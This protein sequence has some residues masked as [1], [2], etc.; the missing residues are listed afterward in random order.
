MAR[1]TKA[2]RNAAPMPGFVPPQL[3]TLRPKLPA[4]AAWIHEAKFDGYRLQLHKH[5]KGVTIYTRSGL[6]WTKRFPTIAADLA[7]L[8]ATRLIIDG[9]LISAGEDG[10]ANFS[11]L[12]DDLKQ[13]RYDRMVFY[14]FDL[15]HSD[16]V[17][18]RPAPLLERKDALGALLADAPLLRILLSE[19]FDDGLA[20]FE[21]AK[22]IGLEGVV[23]KRGDLPYRI[24]RGESWIKV[25]CNKRERF[26]IVG[27][28]HEGSSGIAKLRLAR[29]GT[30]V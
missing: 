2:A 7:R 15:L 30:H 3:A 1:G 21:R 26:V 8:P 12:Q 28:V 6:D 20:L 17:D 4:G 5:D 9:E 25:K 13:G 14:A 19:H 27:F 22:A 18:L 11:A 29:R 24:G 10:M 23:S 16:D